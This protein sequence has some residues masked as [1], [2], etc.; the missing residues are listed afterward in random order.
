MAPKKSL[1]ERMRANPRD[2]WTITQVETL[3]KKIGLDVRKPNGSSHYV[4]SSKYLRDSLCVPYK[5]P[6][7]A[8]YIKNLVSYSDAHAEMQSKDSSNV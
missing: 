1:L 7:R 6:I 2:D 4:V 5:R 3:C 8:L